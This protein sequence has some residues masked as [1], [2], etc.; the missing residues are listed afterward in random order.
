MPCNR[1]NSLQVFTFKNFHFCKLHEVTYY[2]TLQNSNPKKSYFQPK[3]N[4]IWNEM[5]TDDK[6]RTDWSMIFLYKNKLISCFSLAPLS[7][8]LTLAVHCARASISPKSFI[9]A[10]E[11]WGRGYRYASL[12]PWAAR[13]PE[14]MADAAS[15]SHRH[16]LVFKVDLAFC[17]RALRV[18][19]ILPVFVIFISKLHIYVVKP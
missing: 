7:L 11:K 17:I 4:V 16:M 12:R 10:I 1:C 8:Y 14:T 3:I 6:C 18:N 15:F 13:P 9:T 19:S 2:I 5:C